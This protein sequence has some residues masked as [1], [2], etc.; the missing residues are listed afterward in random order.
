MKTLIAAVALATVIASPAFAQTTQRVRVNPERQYVQPN[1][2]RN[3]AAR[4]SYDVYD[5][6]GQYIGSDPDPRVRDEL[7]QDPPNYSD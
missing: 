5:N 2:P 6:R 3:S 7:S 4:S 1:P